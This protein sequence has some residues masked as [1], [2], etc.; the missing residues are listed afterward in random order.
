MARIWLEPRCTVAMSRAASLA[1]LP[2]GVKNTRASSMPETRA[3]SSAKAII[4]SLR[5]S[6]EVCITLAAW[7]CTAATTLGSAWPIMVVSTPPKKS[8]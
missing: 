7:S 1:S 5:Y 2:E 6:V 8:R 3:T 4:G